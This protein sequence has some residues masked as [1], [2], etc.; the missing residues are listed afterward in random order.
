MRAFC[1]IMKTMAAMLLAAVVAAGWYK[2]GWQAAA[3]AAAA[4]SAAYVIFKAAAPEEEEEPAEDDCP[5]RM[6]MDKNEKVSVRYN[7]K[8]AGRLFVYTAGA[9]A[10]ICTA[11]EQ[12]CDQINSDMILAE[13][14][15]IINGESDFVKTKL[16]KT[17]D[18]NK[19]E[20]HAE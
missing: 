10:A 11:A 16:K 5:I 13:A 6:T 18:L 14:E 12:T 9:I 2:I 19:E 15:K 1:A 20:N 4:V 7:V 17:I 3:I 8:G